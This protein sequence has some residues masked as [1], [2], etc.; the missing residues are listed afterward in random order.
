MAAIE[1]NLENLFFASSKPKSHLIPNRSEIQAGRHGSHI[2]NLLF[3]SFSELK[4]Q[5]T[6]NQ[7]WPPWPLSC[8]IYTYIEKTFKNLFF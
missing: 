8:F 2:E 6:R 3:A 5:L 7:R 1:A 4:G